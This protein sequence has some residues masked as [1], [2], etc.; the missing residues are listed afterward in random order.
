MQKYGSL[1][2]VMSHCCKK[3][4]DIC[5]ELETYYFDALRYSVGVME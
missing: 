1:Q 2:K 3:M 4:Y 5:K